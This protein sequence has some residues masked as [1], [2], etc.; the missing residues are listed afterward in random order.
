MADV[1]AMFFL[2]GRCCCHVADVIAIFVFVYLADVIA[3]WLVLLPLLCSVV[4]W[5]M[6]L[7]EG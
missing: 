7:P 5:Q 6:L 2:I 4:Y 3:W 1:V